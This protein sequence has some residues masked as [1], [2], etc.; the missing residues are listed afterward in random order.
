MAKASMT[1]SEAINVAIEVMGADH[2]EAVDRLKALQVQLAKR[3]SGSKGLTKTQKA[4]EVI[5]DKILEILG[6]V[7]EPVGLATLMADPRIPSEASPQKLSA[8]LGQL[9]RSGD[10]VRGKDKKKV[11]Y[12]LADGSTQ[13]TPEQD[14]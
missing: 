13:D 1:Y 6:E 9:V 11:V 2:A 14:A 3:N 4:N 8:L 10:V 7:E 5:K 12:S